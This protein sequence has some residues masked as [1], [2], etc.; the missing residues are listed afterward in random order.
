VA[1][2]RPNGHG[3]IYR[4]ASRPKSPWVFERDLR[5]ADGSVRR[6]KVRAATRTLALQ[7]MSNRE[8][9][10][11]STH[12]RAEQRTIGEF[13]TTWLAHKRPTVRGSTYRGYEQDVRL[14]VLPLIGPKP[15]ASVGPMDVQAVVNAVSASGA[16]VMADRVRRTLK[17]ALRHAVDMDLL[18]VNPADRVAP[19]R[20]P[21]PVRGVWTPEEGE[22]F[23]EEAMRRG[24]AWHALWTLALATGMR[25]GELLALRRSDVLPDRVHVRRTFSPYSPGGFTSPKTRH[26]LRTIPISPG[27]W[28]VLEAHFASCPASDLV[29]PRW[30]GGVLDPTS[31]SAEFRA[32]A[33]ASGVRAIRVHDLRRTFTTWQFAGG[34]EPKRVQ[35]LLGHATPVL[36]LAV[37]ADVLEEGERGSALEVRGSNAGGDAAA[38]GGTGVDA[39]MG[40]KRM[41]RRS[42]AS[43]AALVDSGDADS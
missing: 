21:D 5:L 30:D 36:T 39:S 27:T 16:L 25:K 14:H 28:R 19:V 24:R 17:Q 4:D 31:V 3:T 23:L 11:A 26:G 18:A 43:V 13:L 15:L 10:L 38:L 37:Y 6:V 32:T 41:P 34:A 12:P 29:F 42:R 22:R 20:R 33:A 7:K 1:G 40:R 9:A 2:K 35:R 8:K